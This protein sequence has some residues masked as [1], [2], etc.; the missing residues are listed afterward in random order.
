MQGTPLHSHDGILQKTGQVDIAVLTRL[1]V[2]QL[3]PCLPQHLVPFVRSNPPCI[4][5]REAW[6]Q[7]LFRYILGM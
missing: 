5:E 4:L 3:M 1:V 6:R 7:I 2:A